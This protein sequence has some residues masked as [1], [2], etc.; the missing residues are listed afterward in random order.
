M[1][2]LNTSWFPGWGS[3]VLRILMNLSSSMALQSSTPHANF[4]CVDLYHREARAKYHPAVMLLIFSDHRWSKPGLE[5]SFENLLLS[6]RWVCWRLWSG[7]LYS[8]RST[9]L[10]T[11]TLQQQSH[12]NAEANELEAAWK[13]SLA[14]RYLHV[15]EGGHSYLQRF[16]RTVWFLPSEEEI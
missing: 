8:C 10:R 14:K 2:F 5:A 11:E 7:E 16:H 12:S 6:L 1:S 15:Q 4:N 13:C 9:V 3:P